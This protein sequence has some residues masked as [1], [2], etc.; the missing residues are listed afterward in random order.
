[1][2]KLI[3]ALALMPLFI[4][5]STPRMMIPRAV[6]TIS[7]ASLQDLNLVRSDYEIF[8]T[9]TAE[10]SIRYWQNNQGTAIEMTCPDEDFGLYYAQN[11]K[12]KKGE[13]GWTCKFRGVLKLGYLK[14]DYLGENTDIVQPEELVRRLA[15]YRIINAAK[16]YGADGVIEPI[17][18]TNVEQVGREEVLFRTTV[19][20]KLIKL[21]T[22]R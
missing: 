17:I 15:M 8:Q 9:V 3:W 7:T 18:S 11:K 16:E 19:S 1:M 10:A 20:A 13:T 6:N 5:C 4:S 2:K 22:N 14:N 21:K 12:K